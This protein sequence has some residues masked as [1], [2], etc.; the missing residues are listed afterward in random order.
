[1]LCVDRLTGETTRVSVSSDGT[2]ANG[3]CVEWN[4]VL[5]FGPAISAD[6]RYV[7]FNSAGDIFVYDRLTGETTRVSI[8]SDGTQANGGSWL[9]AISADGRYVAF[10]SDATNLVEGVINGYENIYVHDR[11]MG[12]TTL[13]SVSIDM[14]GGYDSVWGSSIS[15]DGRYMAFGS[16]AGNLVE[17]DTNGV[18]DV[19]VIDLGRIK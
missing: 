9:S 10:V 4:T 14:M 6:G 19:F 2:Q 1:L 7:A 18:G 3:G 15:A 5:T 16:S 12:K 8:S 11:V 13:V 17:G